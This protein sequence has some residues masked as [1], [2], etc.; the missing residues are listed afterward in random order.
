MR[1]M[2][3]TEFAPAQEKNSK[4]LLIALHGLGDSTAGY[5]WLPSAM[6]LPWMNYLLVNA[7]DPYYGGYSWYDFTGDEA[8]G[9]RRSRAMLFTL[10]DAQRTKGFATEETVLFGFSQGCLMTVDVGFRYP[11]RFAGLV[12]VSGYVHDQ[13][14]LLKELSPVAKEQRMLFTHG[15]QDPL[16]PFLKVRQQVD[17]LKAAGLGIEW[18]EFVKAHTI[19]GEEELD[20]IRTFV[21]S[22]FRA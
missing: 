5:R 16:I 13:P 20:L 18:H 21:G 7:P 1:A 10:L 4:R 15:T 8:Q 17:A 12:G 6:K 14:G 9:V 11:H 22:A 3:K 2:L 19:A